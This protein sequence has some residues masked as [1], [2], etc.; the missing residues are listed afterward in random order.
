M[1]GCR[2]PLILASVVAAAAFSLL[3]AG[4][5]G[6]GSPGVANVASSTTSATMPT[7]STTGT[8][9]V[10]Y[11][12]SGAAAQALAFARC[13]RSHGLP[14]LPD[15]E[16]NGEF[17][18]AKLRQLGVS[19]SRARAIEQRFCHYDFENGSQGQTI[20]SADRT[21]YL[22]AAAC[23]RSH[24][25]PDFPDPTFPHNNVTVTIPSSIDQNSS[26][27]KSAAVICIKLIPA[28]LPYSK[29]PGP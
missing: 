17:D 12:T 21:D 1:V 11:G 7:S 25:F 28:G 15:P 20:P 5:G 6:S 24:G 27:F 2:R 29:P 10:Q 23:M 18:K 8:T 9:T 16:S 4:C 19:P 22:K 14:N 26:E 13:M 3:A